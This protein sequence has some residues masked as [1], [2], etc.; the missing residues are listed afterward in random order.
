[1]K[2]RV[3]TP[4]SVGVKSVPAILAVSVAVTIVT[5]QLTRKDLSKSTPLQ[6]A[7]SSPPPG[8]R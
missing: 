3:C 1:M 5:L 6:G 4:R 2:K 8:Q 7:E